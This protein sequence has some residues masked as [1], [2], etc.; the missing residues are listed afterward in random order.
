[1][2]K[3][4]QG[5]LPV[6]SDHHRQDADAT[7]SLA[8]PAQVSTFLLLPSINFASGPIYVRRGGLRL[9]F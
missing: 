6:I 7:F 3:S 4:C 8:F 9:R 1:M 2:K 5:I